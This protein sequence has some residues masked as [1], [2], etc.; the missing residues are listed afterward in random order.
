MTQPEGARPARLLH[1]HSSF[2]LG[3]KEARAVRLMNLWGDRAVHG[4]VSGVAGAVGAKAAIAP[5][6][7]VDFPDAPPLTGAPGLRRFLALARF[8]RRYDLV[9]TYNW[10][11]MD[12]VMAHRLFSGLLSLPPLIHHEDGFN[13]DEAAGLKPA[14][15]LYRRLGLGTAAALVVPSQRLRAIARGAWHQPADRVCHIPNGIDIARYAH[16]PGS[17]ALPGF[18]RT[19]GKLVV[20]TLAGLRAIKNIPRLVRAVAADRDRLQLVVVGEGPERDAVLQEAQVQGLTDMH[21]AGFLPEP[22][23]FMGLF[24]IFAL[25]SDSEQFPIS[26][27]E[28]MAAGLPVVSTDVGDVAAMLAA[29]NLPYVVPVGDEPAFAAALRALAE[30]GA[31]RQ[32]MGER[33]RAHAAAAY[34]ERAMRHAYARIYGNAL[35]RADIFL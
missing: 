4:I 34:G 19:P 32:A 6:V 14:R 29:P 7:A 26:L 30:N 5:D 33:N 3:G 2:N 27:V 35:A 15:N 24:D 11:A 31:L 28:A 8:M 23:R 25:S 1:L 22:W 16:V 10:G 18:V 12:A 17:D 13:E 9:L 21:M 20:G